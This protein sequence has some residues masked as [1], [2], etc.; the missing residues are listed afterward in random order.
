[1]TVFKGYMLMIKR[2]SGL[3]LM[4]FA[5]FIAI[6]IAMGHVDGGS[7]TGSFSA[8]KSDIVIVDLAQSEL[9]K[10]LVAYLEEKHHV[11]VEEDDKSR[12]SEEL[13][14]GKQDV[15]LRIEKDFYEDALA[16][17]TGIHLTQSPGNYAG[18]YLEQQINQFLGNVLSYHSLGYSIS[19]SCKKVMSQKESKV[20]LE[21]INGNGGK[22]PKYGYF[23]MFFPYLFIAAL[24]VALGNILVAFRKRNVKNRM[25][26]SPVSLIRQNIE[27]ILAFLI[28]GTGLYLI[29]IIL[30]FLLYRG[31]LLSASNLG[32][33]LLNGYLDLLAALEIAFLVGMLAKKETAVN[34]F[35]TPISLG[36]C[37]LCGVFVPQSV[38]AAPVKAVGAF[39]PMYWYEK[40]NN[41]LMDYADISKEVGRQVW[42][43]IGIQVLFLFALAGIGLAIA[44]YQQQER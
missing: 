20:T 34:M 10:Q 32:Y 9:S 43:G 28:V 35:I 1:M 2:N 12:L 11:T 8:E 17:K 22:V 37:F 39:F 42:Q 24:G 36:I 19:E 29:C 13:Y 25:M 23:F 16:G 44:K 15:V 40:V 31:D 38:L 14:Y 21:D 7:K 4:Y 6:T 30:S 33:Y 3:T 41:L 27:T 18:M 5:I 26:A